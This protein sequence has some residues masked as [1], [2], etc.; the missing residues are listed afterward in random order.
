MEPVRTNINPYDEKSYYLQYKDE[1]DYTGETI[2]IFAYVRV[3]TLLQAQYGS[4]IDT[5]V[6]L[7]TDECKK[8]HYTDENKKV[9][10]NL[11]RIYVDD[12]ISAKNITDRLGLVEL[13][14]HVTSLVSGRTYQKLGIVISD[15][16]RLTRSSEDLETIIKWIKDNSIKLKFIDSSVDPNTNIGKLMLTMMS[17]FF[18]FERKN[19]AFKTKLTLRSMSENGTLTGHC[20]YG[21]TIGVD[22]SGRKLNVRVPEEQEGL[23]KVI[24]ISRET[25][26]LIPSQIKNVMNETGILCLRGPGKCFRGAAPTEK[27]AK[28]NEGVEW[29]GKWTTQIIEKI[30]EHDQFESR[31]QL[32]KEQGKQSDITKKDEIITQAIKD[33]LNETNTYDSDSFN[34]TAISKAV[35]DKNIFAK[36]INRNY[37]KKLME[38]AKFI[39]PEVIE[40]K[41]D[42][43]G[44]IVEIIRL[45]ILESNIMTYVKLTEVLK[46][47]NIQ[48]V[49]K[50]KAWNTTNVRDLCI[51]YNMTL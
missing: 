1:L 40:K 23:N 36:K 34:F 24:Q 15:L 14:N 48:L 17:A 13:K 16:S 28:M 33:H 51:K 30:V 44:V 25:P 49:G 29:T 11:I 9:K 8:I 4:S 37:V 18:E 10:F 31:Q 27:S 32:V 6:R 20:S 12:G 5:Q 22:E 46:E 45:I 41:K 3:S 7:I 26:E 39:R 21:W 42:D 19:A 35:D 2:N 50:R 43:D 47:K 38:E